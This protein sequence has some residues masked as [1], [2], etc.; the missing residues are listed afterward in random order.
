MISFVK[1]ELLHRGSGFVIVNNQGIGY[2]IYLPDEVAME[3]QGEVALFTHEVMRESEHE[4]FGF[5]S[6]DALELFW[7]FLGVSGVGARSA[8]K[9][10]HADTIDAVRAAIMKGDLSFFTAISGIGKKGAQ[11]I[12]LELK[13]VLA[14]EPA[15]ATFDQDALDALVSLGY[16]RKQAE[17]ILAQID[18]KDTEDAIKQAL[19]LAGTNL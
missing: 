8:Q 12:I 14:E 10:V 15:S 6:A 9:I 16:K 3:L 1:G 19:K 2:K 17:E 7:K 4:L 5:Q 18:A 11:K 13:G